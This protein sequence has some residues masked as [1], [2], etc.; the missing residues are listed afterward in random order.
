MAIR[1][2]L[3]D[4]TLLTGTLA[5]GSETVNIGG[6]KHNTVLINYK[7]DTTDATTKLNLK[8]QVTPDGG[9]TWV[10][11]RPTAVAAPMTASGSYL[12]V[13]SDDADTTHTFVFECSGDQARVQVA[14]EGSPGDFG[15]VDVWVISR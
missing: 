11:V 14:E 10:T 13:D 2:Q 4:D 15:N 12:T 5:A 8:V 7:P 3:H 9:T 1:A 6:E